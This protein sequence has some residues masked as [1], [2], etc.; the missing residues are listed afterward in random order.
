MLLLFIYF[1]CFAA[2]CAVFLHPNA[3]ATALFWCAVCWP[4]L[5][6]FPWAR[7]EMFHDFYRVSG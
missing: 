6:S 1:F 2:T 4:V 5:W 7:A 3:V